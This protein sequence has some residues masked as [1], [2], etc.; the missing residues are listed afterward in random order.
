MN[1]RDTTHRREIAQVAKDVHVV[2][3]RVKPP[4]SA[5]PEQQEQELR[6]GNIHRR[7]ELLRFLPDGHSAVSSRGAFIAGA[8]LCV[9]AST[10]LLSR[11][12]HPSIHPSKLTEHRNSRTGAC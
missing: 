4:L 12:I 10:I 8:A 3:R 7:P 11:S 5:A 9:A 1:K 6:R 2:D